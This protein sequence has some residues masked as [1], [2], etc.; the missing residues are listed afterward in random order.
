M[1]QPPIDENTLSVEDNLE[2]FGP[3]A[4]EDLEHFRREAERLY[5]QT[6]KAILANFGGTAFGDI[7]LVPAPGVKHP[8]GIRD[9]EEWYISTVT[10]RDHVYKIFERQ[11][12][13]GIRNL[14]KIFARGRESRDG[15]LCYR[16][17]L[18]PAERTLYLAEILSATSSS[19]ST[20]KLTAGSIRILSGS[21]SSIP[22]ARFERCSRTLSTR[23]SKSSI[24]SSALLRAWRRKN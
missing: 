21:A 23:V 2:E 24:Q 16:N 14:E 8:K 17:R 15:R 12:E 6:D 1:R 18:R 19:R 11:C 13:I 22:A 3:I 4:D 20:R 9:I 5:T 10:R 7:A